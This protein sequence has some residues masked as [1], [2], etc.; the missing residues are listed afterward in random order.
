MGLNKKDDMFMMQVR[1]FR[2]LQIKWGIKSEKCINIFNKYNINDYIEAC[3]EEFHV[4]GDEANIA[5]IEKYLD[6]RGFKNDF[7]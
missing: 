6:K 5:D 4:Q 3:Y 7:E 2:Q 1:L